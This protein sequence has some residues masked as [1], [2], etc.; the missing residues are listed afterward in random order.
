MDSKYAR[1]ESGDLTLR[2]ELAVDRTLLANERTLLAYLRT[3]MALLIAG[4][5]MIH[6]ATEGWFIAVGLACLPAGLGCGTVGL[7][8]FFRIQQSI[9]SALRK[10][11]IKRSPIP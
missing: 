1:F 8:R 7:V 2:D 9:E 5:T 6:F 10:K 4:A 3:A 11:R